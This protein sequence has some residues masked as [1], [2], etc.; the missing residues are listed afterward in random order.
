MPFSEES[1]QERKSGKITVGDLIVL[2]WLG[3]R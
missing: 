3:V 1:L 2:L